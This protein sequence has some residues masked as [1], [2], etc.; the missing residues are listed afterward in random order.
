VRQSESIY[1]RFGPPSLMVAKFIPGYAAIATSMAGIVRTRR[2][3]FVLFDAIGAALWAGVGVALGWIF[4]DAVAEVLAILEQAGRVGLLLLTAGLIVFIA[5]KA[6]KRYQFRQQ[7]KLPRVSVEELNEMIEAGQ[8]PLVIDVR[9]ASSHAES[10]I[11]GALWIDSKAVESGA[12][13]LPTADEVIVY[14]AC[15]NDASAVLVAKQLMNHGFS[16]VRALHGGIDAWTS[17]GYGVEGLDPS[18]NRPHPAT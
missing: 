10:R 12:K 9:M 3:A 6:W 8:R 15:P 18:D 2:V 5:A 17:A 4:R 16:R 1:E 7:L 14:C 11:P 13:E